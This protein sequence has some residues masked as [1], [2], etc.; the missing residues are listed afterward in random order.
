MQQAPG[1]DLLSSP[2]GRWSA[3]GSIVVWCHSPRL[4]G[5]AAWGRPDEGTIRR[6]IELMG[7]HLHPAIA[8]RFSFVL[9]GSEVEA[10]D[11]DAL[12]VWLDWAGRTLP[13]LLDR[14]VVHAGVVPASMVGFA[15]AGIQPMVGV[16]HNWKVFTGTRDAYRAAS[17]EEGDAVCDEIAAVVRGLRGVPRE[18]AALRAMLRGKGGDLSVAEAARRLGASPRS[19]QRLLLD[20]GTS[21]RQEQC[22]AR[23]AAARELLAGSDLKIAAIAARLGITERSLEALFR[24][25]DMPSP[26]EYR[27]SRRG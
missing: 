2:L 3:A 8:R 9:D 5:A 14:I 18:L 17:P 21:F 22:E 24:S 10:V 20:E 25:R 11:P 7:I 15:I 1:D 26:A 23:L 27:R 16:D 4:L 19:L 13:S 6:M 12:Q